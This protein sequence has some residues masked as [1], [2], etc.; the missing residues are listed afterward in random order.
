MIPPQ[1]L[2]AKWANKPNSVAGPCFV[3]DLYTKSCQNLC[4]LPNCQ[5]FAKKKTNCQSYFALLVHVQGCKWYGYFPTVSESGSSDPSSPDIQHPIPYPYLDTQIN[6]IFMMSIFI[7][8]LSNIACTIRIWIRIQIWIKIWKQMQYQLAISVRIRSTEIKLCFGK[9]WLCLC[10]FGD[11]SRSR[12]LACLEKL[13]RV[14]LEA[15]LS[16]SQKNA[17]FIFWEVK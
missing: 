7:R 3:Y 13:T 9:I 15:T 12:K 8:I 4:I 6:R 17:F 2:S 10:L 11:F 5:T 1:T 14:W 16:P